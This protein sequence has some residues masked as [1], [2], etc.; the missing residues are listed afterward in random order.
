M[1]FGNPVSGFWKKSENLLGPK[2]IVLVLRRRSR[3]R[4]LGWSGINRL[5]LSI[6]VFSKPPIPQGPNQR[7][8]TRTRTSIQES[9]GFFGCDMNTEAACALSRLGALWQE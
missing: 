6:T 4:S 9:R 2:L 1:V 8:R 7:T 5:V 3:P